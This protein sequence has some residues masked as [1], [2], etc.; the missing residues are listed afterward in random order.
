MKFTLA[1]TI[2]SAAAAVNAAAAPG[3]EPSRA[4]AAANPL[5]SQIRSGAASLSF[6]LAE[7]RYVEPVDCKAA[8]SQTKTLALSIVQ[9]GNPVL[10]PESSLISPSLTAQCRSTSQMARGSIL[11]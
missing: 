7:G 3:P 4:I 11:T 1:S 5:G 9:G 6:V 8:K 10:G 2:L